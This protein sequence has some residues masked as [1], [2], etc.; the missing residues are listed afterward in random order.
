MGEYDGEAESGDGDDGERG[1][2]GGEELGEYCMRLG[3]DGA[4]VGEGSDDGASI[5]GWCGKGLEVP[6]ARSLQ[7]Y[8]RRPFPVLPWAL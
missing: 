5:M 4:E 1:E 3:Y 2:R 8:G 7:A 6:N